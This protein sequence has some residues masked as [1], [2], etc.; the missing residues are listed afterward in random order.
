MMKSGASHFLIEEYTD[1]S[2]FS[3]NHHGGYAM[4]IYRITDAGSW[5]STGG[6]SRVPR[7]IPQDA[8]I[9]SSL[10]TGQDASQENRGILRFVHLVRVAKECTP[11]HKGTTVGEPLGILEVRHDLSP[12]YAQA[13]KENLFQLLL[14]APIP[15]LAAAAV[16]RILTAR[17]RKS[18][19]LVEHR[20]ASQGESGIPE[21]AGAPTVDLGFVEFN[22]LFAALNEKLRRAQRR[23]KESEAY[24]RSLIENTSD[25]ISVLDGEGGIRYVSPAVERILGYRPD[26]LIDKDALG[27]VHPDDALKM[28]TALGLIMTR[29][30]TESFSNCRF[31]CHDGCWRIL[32]GAG[33]IMPDAANVII[34]A[35][36]VTDREQMV[37]SLLEN[38]EKYRSLFVSMR[39]GVAVLE[40]L[41]DAE[42]QPADVRIRDVN[43]AFEKILGMTHEEIVTR[44]AT[45]LPAEW[46]LLDAAALWE[47]ATSG[48]S[49]DCETKIKSAGKVMRIDIFATGKDRCALILDVACR[50]RYRRASLSRFS[51]RRSW[52]REPGWASPLFTALSSRAVASYW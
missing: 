34:A 19:A 31:K 41:R 35:H 38:E 52:E 12:H 4:Q 45:E 15:L 6:G 2:A 47:R 23:L 27:F 8:L 50:P 7:R 21:I 18:V 37:V 48:K 51:L 42:G 36:D 24:F 3:G 39:E 32:E 40:I 43:P 20:F 33:K 30:G 10:R 11:C 13:R 28:R 16:S 46:M 29:K 1:A 44:N 49:L 22:E 14:W 17:I 25:I 9:E 26:E 5:P